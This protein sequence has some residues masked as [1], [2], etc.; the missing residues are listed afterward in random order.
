MAVNYAKCPEGL[1]LLPGL[2][3]GTH[4]HY[5]SL[6]WGNYTMA[7]LLMVLSS[8]PLYDPLPWDHTYTPMSLI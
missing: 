1:N 7:V 2:F 6:Q 5:L 3:T 8:T 4:F